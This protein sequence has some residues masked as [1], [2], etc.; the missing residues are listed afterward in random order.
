MTTA[1]LVSGAGVVLILAAFALSTMKK[2]DNNGRLYFTLNAAGGAVACAGAWLVG[3]VPFM[4][5]EA[6]WT[7]V[8]FVG[9][10]KVKTT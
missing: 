7:V 6:V 9:L 1:D 8:A 2:L 10:L 3:S 5:L 4:V